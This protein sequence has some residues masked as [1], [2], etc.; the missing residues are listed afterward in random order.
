MAFWVLLFILSLLKFNFTVSVELTFELYD[1]A[2]DCFYE[3]IDKNTST[4]LEYQVV[5]G[6]QYDVDVAIEDPRGNLLYQQYKS[7]FDSHTFMPEMSG[8]YA[9]CFSNEFSTIS[10]KIVYMDL[11]V[12]DEKPLPIIGEHITVMTLIES[13][14]QEIHRKLN[15]INDFQTH[16]RL[17]EAS[18]R[19]RA[20]D[21][22][23]T[24]FWWCFT[25]TCVILVTMIS[26]VLIVRNFFTDSRSFR[27]NV[28]H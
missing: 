21:L 13:S 12:G 24:V 25:E 19:K 27:S 16:H 9:F 3:I 20:E 5:T 23:Q 18:S 4:T 8:V 2:K 14:S 1:N 6:G 11:Q 17:R 28:R 26:Q 15:V 22:N 10:H 7:Q